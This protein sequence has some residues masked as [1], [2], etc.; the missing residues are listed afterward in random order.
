VSGESKRP[1]F[2]RLL[3]GDDLPAA[4][5]TADQVLWLVD[6]DAVGDATLPG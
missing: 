6:P 1:A 4:R 3:A 5:V 2:Q